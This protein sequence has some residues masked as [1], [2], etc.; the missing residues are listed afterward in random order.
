FLAWLD[1]RRAELLGEPPGGPAHAAL[2]ADYRF[3]ALA[4]LASLAFCCGWS[5]PL[6]AEGYRL[7]LEGDRLLVDPDPFGG[8]TVRLA[9]RARRVEGA[10]FATAADLRRALAR[11]TE[12]TIAG[13]AAGVR[14]ATGSDA[15]RP[16]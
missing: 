8:T 10:R 4:D 15:P 12:T 16:N 5:G 2:D 9:V 7:Q 13:E 3:V 11:A 14:T 6:E 1:R